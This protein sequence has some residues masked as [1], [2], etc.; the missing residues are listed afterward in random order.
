VSVRR[1]PKAAVR[2]RMAQT[3]ETH[4]QA[5]SALSK[6]VP[7]HHLL[8]PE[9]DQ[10][11]VGRCISEFRLADRSGRDGGSMV[12]CARCLGN[13]CVACGN[14]PVDE[15]FAQCERCSAVIAWQERADQRRA[16]CAG[17][18]CISQALAR[19]SDSDS[20]S[21]F[22]DSCHEPICFQC[23]RQPV[24]GCF[25]ICDTGCAVDHGYGSE[26]DIEAQYCQELR[27]EV[28]DAV[29]LIVKLGGGTRR[30]VFARVHRAMQ[31]RL[32]DATSEQ[33]YA[34]LQ[35]A[36]GWIWQLRNGGGRTG[37]ETTSSVR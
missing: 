34:V 6:Q 24:V 25:E 2:A 9:T 10:P 19:T 17:C 22:C 4:Q 7:E 5:Q 29:G 36:G 1:V 18:R 14:A 23:Q 32:A 3:G 15:P 8:P 26:D 27:E 20:A 35:E 21:E 33:L 37:E 13:V 12:T 11:C 28:D 30:Q 31:A 16:R